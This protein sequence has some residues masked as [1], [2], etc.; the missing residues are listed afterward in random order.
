MKLL[1][2]NTWGATQGQLFFD[3]I[4]EEAKTVDVF[5]FQE[6]FFAQEPAPK[7]S[8]GASMYLF[9]ELT[10]LLPEFYGIFAKRSSGYDFSGP[11]DFWL[12]YGMAVFIRNNI[13]VINSRVENWGPSMGTKTDPGEGNTIAQVLNL[14]L[15][16]K[17]FTVINY[18]GPAQPGE[19]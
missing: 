11:V 3:Y 2:L 17:F 12:K 18:H 4:K 9:Q 15:R 7:I 5:C 16:E 8:S 19:K 6:I 13:K 1:S 14:A 10:G